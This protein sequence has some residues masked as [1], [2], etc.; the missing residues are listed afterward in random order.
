MMSHGVIRV[1]LSIV[2]ASV[3]GQNWSDRLQPLQGD[4]MGLWQSKVFP[5]GIQAHLK[6][7]GLCIRQSGRA[8]AKEGPA[9]LCCAC[10]KLC[11]SGK[12]LKEASKFIS[13]G[14]FQDAKNRIKFAVTFLKAVGEEFKRKEFPVFGD[15]LISCASELRESVMDNRSMKQIKLSFWKSGEA[16]YLA[17]RELTGLRYAVARRKLVEASIAFGAIG[18]LK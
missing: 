18:D 6:T 11:W 8:I 16:L 5:E 17:A 7:A 12:C 10:Q 9:N 2:C 1:A 14:K 3:A 4:T 13:D 15:E